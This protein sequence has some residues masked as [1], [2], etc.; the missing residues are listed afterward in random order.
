M[1]VNPQRFTSM[2]F[3]QLPLLEFLYIQVENPDDPNSPYA[4]HAGRKNGAITFEQINSYRDFLNNIFAM[5]L[6]E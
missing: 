3:A 1:F 6:G 2:L 4:F 5:Y